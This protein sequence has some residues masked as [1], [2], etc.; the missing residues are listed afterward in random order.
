MEKQFDQGMRRV[1]TQRVEINH[2]RMEALNAGELEIHV[3]PL[4]CLDDGLGGLHALSRYTCTRC[5]LMAASLTFHKSKSD[6]EDD[7]ECCKGIFF[8][9]PKNMEMNL[10]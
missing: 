2:N 7:R 10:N 1:R 8:N 3:W 9:L 4:N 5:I 6:A